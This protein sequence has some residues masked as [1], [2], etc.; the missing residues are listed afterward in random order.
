MAGTLLIKK[1]LEHAV[2]IGISI[3]VCY[4]RT[5]RYKALIVRLNS[6]PLYKVIVTASNLSIGLELI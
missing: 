2:V 5:S 6:N 4:L 3:D 1:L